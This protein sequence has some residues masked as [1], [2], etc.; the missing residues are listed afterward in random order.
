M[1]TV[2]EGKLLRIFIAESDK[3][4]GR[5]LHEVIMKKARDKKMSGATI[6]K[7]C[8]GF[9]HKSNMHTPKLLRLSENLPLIVEIIDTQEN[10]ELFMP[11]LDE[12][13]GEGIVTLENIDITI[14]RKNNNK[15]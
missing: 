12:I 7:G 15:S 1:K 2:Q 11:C 14:Y 4:N 3:H 13:I 6:L 5:P 10:I 9:G 8:M